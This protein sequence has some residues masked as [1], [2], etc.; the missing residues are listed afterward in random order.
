MN[1][2]IYR[3]EARKVFVG[4]LAAEV[5][6]KDFAD[7]FS[8]FGVVKVRSSDSISMLYGSVLILVYITHMCIP[9]KYMLPHMLT[10]MY[11]LT[12]YIYRTQW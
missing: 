7:Y 5:T 1:I 3:S 11:I 10:H 4:G 12:R 6:E 8:Q 2:Y 9:Y